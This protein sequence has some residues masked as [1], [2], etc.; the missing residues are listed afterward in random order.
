MRPI[1]RTRM[2]SALLLVVAFALGVLAA[3]VQAGD[4]FLPLVVGA[5]TVQETPTPLGTVKVENVHYDASHE[6]FYGELVNETPCTVSAAGVTLYLLDADGLPIGNETGDSMAPI[7][8]PGERTPFR[9]RWYDTIP[10]WDSYVVTVYWDPIDRL[11]IERMDATED[12]YGTWAGTAVVRNQLPVR[13]QALRVGMVLTGC[14]GQV[15]GYTM[16]WDIF[17]PLAPGDV[18]TV[19][20]TFYSGTR[21]N[22][23]KAWGCAAF[24]VPCGG[25]RYSLLGQG[26]QRGVEGQ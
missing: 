15:I 22:Y 1:K 14:N 18:L 23:A 3:S 24:A 10:T 19:T 13:V 21:D 20:Q 17:G 26:E 16:P 9:V 25:D 6:V 4:V 12:W 8:L 2:L 5:N 7:L 11:T